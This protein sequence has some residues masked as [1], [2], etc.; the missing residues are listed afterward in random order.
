MEGGE[1]QYIKAID[2]SFEEAPYIDGGR[3]IHTMPYGGSATE[4]QN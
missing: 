4:R 3:N 2:L 1:F